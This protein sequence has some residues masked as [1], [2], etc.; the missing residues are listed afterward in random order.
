MTRISVPRRRPK[1][2]ELGW[3]KYCPASSLQFSLNKFAV[4]LDVKG[5]RIL[6]CQE[7][8][9]P[10]VKEKFYFQP[11]QFRGTL[12]V[13]PRGCLGPVHGETRAAIP[14]VGSAGLS[15]QPPSESNLTDRVVVLF[16]RLSVNPF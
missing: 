3:T 14:V 15:V 11:T 9:V 13:Y 2:R 5:I 4:V 12:R 7:H 1:G 6:I 16:S 10:Y 8:H